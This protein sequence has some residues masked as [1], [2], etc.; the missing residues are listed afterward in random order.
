MAWTILVDYEYGEWFTSEPLV[1]RNAILKKVAMLA[2]GGPSLSREAVDTL[3]GSSIANLK[4]LRIQ[5][6]G[7]PYRVLFAFDPRRRAILL[8]GGNK[9]GDKRWYAVNIPIA[10]ARFARHLERMTVD[11]GAGKG[12]QP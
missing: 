12:G 11:E 8:V 2:E 10:E 6:K 9:A 1:V 4:E 5:V 7:D 3:S